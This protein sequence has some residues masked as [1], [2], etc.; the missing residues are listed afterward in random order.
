MNPKDHAKWATF[1]EIFEAVAQQGIDEFEAIEALLTALRV[2][3]CAQGYRR[4]FTFNET[5]KVERLPRDIHPQPVPIAIW[6]DSGEPRGDLTSFW[7]DDPEE[8]EV[9]ISIDWISGAIQSQAWE[10]T[11]FEHLRTEFSAVRV[12]RKEAEHLLSALA[13]KPKKRAGRPQGPTSAWEKEQVAEAM[14]MIATGDTRPPTAIA[15]SLTDPK[16]TGTALESQER[17]LAWGIRKAIQSNAKN[18]S[19]E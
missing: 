19:Q 14:R 13:G 2:G 16:L 4:Q 1:G 5:G 8:P 17:R 9:W 3:L 15:T 18:S 11:N 7:Q 12:P 10:M 6:R